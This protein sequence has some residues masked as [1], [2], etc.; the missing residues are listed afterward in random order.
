MKCLAAAKIRSCVALGMDLAAGT[1][2][3]TREIAAAERP[4]WEESV[5]REAGDLPEVL[6][7]LDGVATRRVLHRDKEFVLL[8]KKLT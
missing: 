3:R 4:R 8:C 2:L 5:A 6:R 7:D 1:R